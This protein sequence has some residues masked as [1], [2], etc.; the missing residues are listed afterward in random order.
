MADKLEDNKNKNQHISQ[1]NA[2][3][4]TDQT[5]TDNLPS[6]TQSLSITTCTLKR[7]KLIQIMLDQM[8]KAPAND[9]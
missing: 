4:G 2:Q 8:M 6:H 9:I 7:T 3:E 1:K 5:P